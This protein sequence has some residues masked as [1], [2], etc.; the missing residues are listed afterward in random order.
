MWDQ[1][2]GYDT[3]RRGQKT[4][5][6]KTALSSRLCA[7]LHK[8]KAGFWNYASD[9][10]GAI[11]VETAIITPFVLFGLLTAGSLGLSAYNHQKVYTAAYSGASFL[12]D[13]IGSGDLSGLKSTQNEDGETEPGE[14]ISTAKLVI[15]DASGLPL[16]LNKIDIQTYCACPA[17]NPGELQNPNDVD[18]MTGRQSFYIRQ[19]IEVTES[20]DICSSQCTNGET[21]RIIAEIIIDYD[22]ATLKGGKKEVREKL[23]TRL[24]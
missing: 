8:G 2:M 6:K 3:Y 12:H 21:S 15:K 5:L 14:W 16:D 19:Q 17:M 24:R 23:V 20:D 9:R 13:K 18:E 10:S 1:I 7:A 11:A 4:V 22:A